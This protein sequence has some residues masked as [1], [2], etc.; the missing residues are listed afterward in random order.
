MTCVHM[1]VCH[2]IEGI[3]LIEGTACMFESGY[4]YMYILKSIAI[5][6]NIG[7]IVP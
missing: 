4:M 7:T 3:I 6:E 1:R 2:L 5:I